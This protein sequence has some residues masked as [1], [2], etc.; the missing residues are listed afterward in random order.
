MNNK[1]L[2]AIAASA[3][4]AMLS[5]GAF[6]AKG[7]NYT[8]VDGGYRGIFADSLD[9]N[10][11]TANLS[12]G[13]TDHIMVLAGYSHLWQDE[14]EGFSSV[15]VD[16]DEFKIGGGGHYSITDRIDLVGSLVYVNE[17]S[18]GKAKYPFETSKSRVKGTKEGY[19][20]GFSGRIQT[21]KKLELTPLVVYHDVGSDS[22]TGFG[23]NAIYKFHKKWSVRGNATYFSD[24]SAT[25]L[26]LGF[27]FDM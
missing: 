24:D 10:G 19:E 20:V 18:S 21:T 15:D 23:L 22:D 26:F 4:L 27:R 7:F 5:Q 14:A 12:F 9:A 3:C 2:L 25:N 6:A 1:G 8:Y 11:F 13:A 16:I 17:Q